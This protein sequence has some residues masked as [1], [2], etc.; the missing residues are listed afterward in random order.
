VSYTTV[1]CVNREPLNGDNKGWSMVLVTVLGSWG[2]PPPRGHFAV[3]FEQ[4]S[5]DI[6]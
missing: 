6:D 5:L 2:K 1:I 3:L 4:P